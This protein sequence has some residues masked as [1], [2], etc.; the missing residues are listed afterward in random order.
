MSSKDC[1]SPAPTRAIV[2]SATKSSP[3]RE[4]VRVSMS[5]PTRDARSALTILARMASRSVATMPS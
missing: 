5:V 1:V 2:A 3:R 4:P